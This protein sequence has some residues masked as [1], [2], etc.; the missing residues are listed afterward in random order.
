LVGR[1]SWSAAD[2]LVG[3]LNC[4]AKQSKP[5]GDVRRGSGEPPYFAIRIRES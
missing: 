2:V 3:L 1:T 4:I 5:D